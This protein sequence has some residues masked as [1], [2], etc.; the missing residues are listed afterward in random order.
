MDTDPG[1]WNEKEITA[2][3]KWCTKKFKMKPKPVRSR[4]PNTGTEL[5]DLTK[6]DF[7]VVADGSRVGGN[8]LAQYIALM[9]HNATG[10][11]IESLHSKEDPGERKHSIFI[12]Q[13]M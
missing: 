1:T 2:W 13:Y 3:L 9:V 12:N 7:W 11:W 5:V 10:R 4:L 6:A 8:K